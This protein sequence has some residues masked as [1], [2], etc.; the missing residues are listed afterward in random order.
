MVAS[1]Q[2]VSGPTSPISQEKQIF[3]VLYHN[4]RPIP[5]VLAYFG[6]Q[7]LLPSWRRECY[8]WHVNPVALPYCTATTWQGARRSSLRPTQIQGGAAAA[9]SNFH[10]AWEV[11]PRSHGLHSAF[12]RR[13]RVVTLTPTRREHAY[14][15]NDMPLAPQ[16]ILTDELSPWLILYFRT[17]ELVRA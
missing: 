6:L 17:L 8:R 12:A 3:D 13:Q 14:L 10:Y 5:I 16:N 4:D 11:L 1:C 2:V 9:T 7:N 15:F